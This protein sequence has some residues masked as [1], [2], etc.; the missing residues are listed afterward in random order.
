V[1]RNCQKCKRRAGGQA[2]RWKSERVKKKMQ[3]EKCK[4]K[5][6]KGKMQMAKCNTRNAKRETSRTGKR[7]L[8]QVLIFDL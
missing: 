7:L 2:E 8:Y 3:K 6:A 5:K 1:G 4:T